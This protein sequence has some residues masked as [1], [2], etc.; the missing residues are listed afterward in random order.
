MGW[1]WQL[2]RATLDHQPRGR[3]QT[4]RTKL[5]EARVR[6]TVRTRPVPVM[7]RVRVSINP[8]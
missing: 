6:R 3:K 5:R 4:R 1:R 7:P 8:A 2:A